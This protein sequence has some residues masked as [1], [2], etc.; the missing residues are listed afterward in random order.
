[1]SYFSQTLVFTLNKT[2]AKVPY[3]VISLTLTQRKIS[4]C[5]LIVSHLA[6][7]FSALHGNRGFITALI[8]IKNLY[9]S[10]AR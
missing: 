1:M 10:F 7:K 8:T 6:E 4:V 9:L 3:F 2:N 5:E